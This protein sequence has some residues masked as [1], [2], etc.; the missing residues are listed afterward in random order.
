VTTESVQSEGRVLVVE[1]ETNIGD[2][3]GTALRFV[4]FEVELAQSG[5]E[6]VAK[7]TTWRPDIILLDVMLPDFDGFEVLRRLRLESRHAP[8]IFLT[9]RDSTADAVRGLTVGGDDYITKPFSLEEVIARVRAVLRRMGA[10]HTAGAVATNRL[11]FA[12]L[13]MDEDQLQVTRAGSKIELSP[14]EYK[15]LRYLLLNTN[16]VLS[17][18]MILD[19]VWQYDFGGE[20]SVVET[21]ISYLRKKLDP[22]GP[23]IIHTVRGFGYVMRQSQPANS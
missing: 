11:M 7:A 12:D 21:Y 14:T 3:L 2:L 8:V 22:Y 6:A 16:R 17:K 18:S 19:H 1:D 9:A 23:P 5:R 20:G 15:L 13:E 10:A 4:G